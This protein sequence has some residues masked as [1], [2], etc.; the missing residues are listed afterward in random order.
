MRIALSLALVLAAC[1]STREAEPEQ[2]REPG[3][4]LVFTAQEGWAEEEPSSGMRTAQYA[5]GEASLVVFHFGAAGGTVE[6]NF[7]RWAS[8]FEQPGGD[9]RSIGASRE[10]TVSGMPVHEMYM[11]GTY[12][13]ET[14]PG[15]GER[16]N[17][18]GWKMMA[19][20]IES[21]HGPYYV[22]LTGP[23]EVVRHWAPSYD[24]FLEAV[25]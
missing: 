2:P 24:A 1:S 17:H 10:R 16:V 19:A 22:K 11:S 6:A 14:A 21:D 23:E 8:Q 3:A 12:V 5:L 7:E 13:A 15:S 20:I 4:P 18:E 25:R 9:D